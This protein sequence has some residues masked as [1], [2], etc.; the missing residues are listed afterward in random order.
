MIFE[1]ESYNIY[2]QRIEALTLH[3]HHI[4]YSLRD[5]ITFINSIKDCTPNTQF[6]TL[7]QLTLSA[8][9]DTHV[10][11]LNLTNQK[12]DRVIDLVCCQAPHVD[13]TTE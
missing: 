11:G 3:L 10:G 1:K 4:K 13:P 2:I 7:Q 5:T 9:I 12:V 6:K 8:I